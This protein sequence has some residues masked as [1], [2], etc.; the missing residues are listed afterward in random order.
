[1]SGCGYVSI[2]LNIRKWWQVDGHFLE[3]ETSGSKTLICIRI[4]WE[5][6]KL[7]GPT[8]RVSDLADMA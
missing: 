5:L 4:N 1:M 7:E 8:P 2:K 3:P 6:V